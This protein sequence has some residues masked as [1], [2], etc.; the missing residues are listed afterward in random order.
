MIEL[1]QQQSCGGVTT[2]QIQRT[3]LSKKDIRSIKWFSAW[4]RFHKRHEERK[5]WLRLRGEAKENK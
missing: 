3:E 5:S 1:T 4:I 2:Q